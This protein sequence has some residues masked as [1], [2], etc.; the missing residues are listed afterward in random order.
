MMENC[1]DEFH[2]FK[3]RCNASAALGT[4]TL[5]Q[6]VI[7]DRGIARSPIQTRTVRIRDQKSPYTGDYQRRIAQAKSHTVNGACRQGVVSLQSMKEST[8][9]LKLRPA[10]MF[11]MHIPARPFYRRLVRWFR[12]P[13]SIRRATGRCARMAER[14]RTPLLGRTGAGLAS[15]VWR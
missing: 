15:P 11:L 12:K 1:H 4:P 7:C 2:A 10:F 3:R 5:A 9:F 8:Y 14:R 13:R 6:Q